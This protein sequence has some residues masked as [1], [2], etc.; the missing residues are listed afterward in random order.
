VCTAAQPPVFRRLTLPFAE[1]ITTVAR[2][3]VRDYITKLDEQTGSSSYVPRPRVWFA[4]SPLGRLPL[5]SP[6]ASGRAARFCDSRRRPCAQSLVQGRR[7]RRYV[8]LSVP[9]ASHPHDGGPSQH[10][11]RYSPFIRRQEHASATTQPTSLRRSI[12]SSMAKLSTISDQRVIL[13]ARPW[14][15]LGGWRVN[16]AKC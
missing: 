14:L 15:L 11:S 13:R 16:P 1:N 12:F 3:G 5:V 4:P 9:R 6:S 2:L 8:Q 10:W 7:H